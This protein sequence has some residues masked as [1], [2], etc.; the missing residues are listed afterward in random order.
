MKREIVTGSR[1][2]GVL[3]KTIPILLLILA[4]V[5]TVA[6]SA[7]ATLSN[8]SATGAPST[9]YSPIR[10]YNAELGTSDHYNLTYIAGAHG[11]ISGSASQTVNSGDDGSPVT[12]VPDTCYH[13][14]SWNDSSTAN[15]RTDHEVSTNITKIANF[16]INT[17]SPAVVTC[18]GSG[19]PRKA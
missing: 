1:K 11:N 16:S 9:Q 5:L 6:I 19:I 15:P 18:W 7:T 17:C 12:A 3:L 10:A 8:V 2:G 4:M 14:V 13:F